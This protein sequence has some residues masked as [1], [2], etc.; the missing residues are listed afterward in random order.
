MSATTTQ[1]MNVKIATARFSLSSTRRELRAPALS[2][3][4]KSSAR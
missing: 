2:R 4:K 3:P 1:P